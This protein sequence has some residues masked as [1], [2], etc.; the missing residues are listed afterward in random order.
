MDVKITKDGGKTLVTLSG[1]VDTTTA[2]QFRKTWLP[3]MRMTPLS[4]NLTALIWTIP[5]ARV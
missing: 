3:S 1:R 5:Q 2:E 4:S